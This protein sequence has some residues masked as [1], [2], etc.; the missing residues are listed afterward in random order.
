MAKR[1]ALI[2]LCAG[3]LSFVVGCRVVPEWHDCRQTM[4]VAQCVGRPVLYSIVAPIVNVLMALGVS[5]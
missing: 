4:T 1:F 2:V 5:S 3:W